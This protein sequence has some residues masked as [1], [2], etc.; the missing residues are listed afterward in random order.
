MVATDA[1]GTRW[2][3]EDGVSGKLVPVGDDARLAE[4]LRGYLDDPIRARAHG[5]AGRRIAQAR[6]RLDAVVDRTLGAYHDVIDA[7]RAPETEKP[8]DRDRVIA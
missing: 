5:A 7:A 4:A 6:F 8:L 1:G 2:I 3:V